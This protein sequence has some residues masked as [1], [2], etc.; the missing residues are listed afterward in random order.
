MA[1]LDNCFVDRVVEPVQLIEIG[2]A[3]QPDATPQGPPRLQ[4]RPNQSTFSSL[5][6][7]AAHFDHARTNYACRYVSVPSPS[8][9]LMGRTRQDRVFSLT[10]P[11]SIC[12]R[13]SWRPLQIT[14]AMIDLLVSQHDIN[15][16][17][18]DLPSCFYTRNLDLEEVFCV[19]YT[20][21][22]NGGFIGGHH[23]GCGL[24]NLY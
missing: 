16:S 23:Q 10:L 17:F 20:E 19:P 12:Q 22:R 15:P 24:L 6:E 18:W 13:N 3:A 5:Q 2:I 9:D 4:A 7:L 11:S 21:T 14:K 8:H 1:P